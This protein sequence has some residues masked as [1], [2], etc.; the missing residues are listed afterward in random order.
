MYAMKV[1]SSI[2]GIRAPK[3]RAPHFKE[4]VVEFPERKSVE[5]INKELLKEGIFGGVDLRKHFPEL[6]N[7]ALYCFTEVHMKEDID[8]LADA[9][10]RILG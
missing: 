9:L 6:G 2:D 7:S 8:K 5:E 4:F 3:F 1:L 10:K